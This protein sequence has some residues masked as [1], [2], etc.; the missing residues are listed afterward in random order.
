MDFK[1]YKLQKIPP[2]YRYKIYQY[3][4][5][6]DWTKRFQMIMEDKLARNLIDLL[7]TNKKRDQL[8]LLKG[9]SFTSFTLTKLIFY[10]Y[11]NLGYKFSYYSSEQLPKGIKYTDLPYVIEL[12]ENEKDID[13]IG[14]TEL[15]E[16]QL[17]NIIKHRKRIIAKFIEKEDQWH[18]FYITYKSLSGEESW[19][20]GQPHYH[21][22]SDKFGVPRDEVVLGI[23]NG[24]MPS[25]PV[26]IGIEG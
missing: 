5:H 8:K 10:A 21:Y 7:T 24:K 4:A 14:E 1:D 2:E 16:G 20:D 11:E 6:Q 26:H 9:V 23:K 3:E 13:I 17:K 18:C 15:S 12:G 19:N 25:T 22:L